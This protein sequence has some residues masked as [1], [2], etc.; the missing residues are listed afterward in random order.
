MKQKWWAK[1]LWKSHKIICKWREKLNKCQ[2][3]DQSWDTTIGK[4]DRCEK[5]NLMV[6]MAYSCSSYVK[7]DSSFITNL[8]NMETT[9]STAFMFSSTKAMTTAP[10]KSIEL[11]EYISPSIL[12]KNN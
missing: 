12:F 11:F 3:L 4:E 6:H 7:L 5:E 10:L 1:E 2:S 8:E 9:E